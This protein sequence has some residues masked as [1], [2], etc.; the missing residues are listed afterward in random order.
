MIDNII[1]LVILLLDS[2]FGLIYYKKCDCS[3]RLLTILL[4][5]TFISETIS[6]VLSSV[7]KN[8]S[9]PEK[10]Y[11]PVHILLFSSIYY[12]LLRSPSYQKIIVTLGSVVFIGALVVISMYSR[13]EL[14]S[15]IIMIDA[16]MLVAFSILYFFEL[17]HE[18]TEDKILT[19]GPFWLNTSVLIY[20]SGTFIFF[21]SFEYLLH[22]NKEALIELSA[23]KDILFDPL[24]YLLLGLALVLHIR[25]QKLQYGYR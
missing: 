23:I 15:W 22:N 4:V 2:L 5:F 25:R 18:P 14:P 6:L 3:F 21:A 1:Y 20:F 16:A 24:H 19:S 13:R 10:I 12:I 17:I 11:T 9:L 7:T 8:D